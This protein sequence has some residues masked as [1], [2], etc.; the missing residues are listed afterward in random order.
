MKSTHVFLMTAL[1]LIL[2]VSTTITV[3]AQTLPSDPSILTQ[4][5]CQ[6]PCWYN[7]LPGQSTL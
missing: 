7:L 4:S 6:L 2:F 3:G 1:Y 5:V